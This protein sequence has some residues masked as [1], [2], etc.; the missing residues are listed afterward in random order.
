MAKSKNRKAMRV[1]E[2]LITF[3]LLIV[4]YVPV[5]GIWHGV[6]FFPLA[7]YIFS[8]L[9]VH[10]GSFWTEANFLLFSKYNMFGRIVAFCGI[11]LFLAAGVQFLRMR[12]KPITTGLYSVVRHPQYLGI[13]IL[14]FGYSFMVIQV[15][16]PPLSIGIV[17]TVLFIWLIQVVGYIALAFYEERRLLHEYG[18]EYQQYK[19]KVPFIFPFWHP[20]RIPEPI[21]SFMLALIIVFF[22]MLLFI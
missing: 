1:V 20:S 16:T 19:H 18:N 11:A 22:C 7:V 9:A 3:F 2:A 10:P 17:K 15:T 12:E 8:L 4:Q 13:I 5:V 21:F 14:T 6:M